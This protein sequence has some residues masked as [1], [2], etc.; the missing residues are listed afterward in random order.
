M[1]PLLGKGPRPRGYVR[2]TAALFSPGAMSSSKALADHNLDLRMKRLR[3]AISGG[4][5]RRTSGRT[6][7][8]RALILAPGGRLT[9]RSVPAPL[10]P[11]PLG[12]IVHPIAMATCDL[13]RAMGLGHTPF[14]LPLQ[15]GHE[16]V[17]EVVAIGSEVSRIRVGQVVVVPFQISCGEC[18][19][20]LAGHTGNCLSVPPVSMYG[21][22][23]GGGHWGGTLADELAVPFAD[24]VLVPL[25][26]GVDPAAAASVGD[27]ISDAHRHVAPYLPGILQRDPEA[28]VLI[29]AT[30]DR[31]PI[32]TPSCALYAG[33][34]ALA[35]GGTRVTYVDTRQGARDIAAGLGMTAM[36]PRDLRG[37]PLA[38]LVI[39]MTFASRGHRL[40][41]SHIAPDGIC[42]NAGSLHR[43]GSI[44][45]SLM[46]ARN[47]TLSVSR[48]HARS[49]IP[50]VLELMADGRV[51]PELV[52]TIQT[53]LDDA[54][55]ALGAHL[56]GQ[57]VKTVLTA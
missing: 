23:L 54:K 49:Q 42:S 26:A 12:A 36:S 22:G 30:V 34:F 32:F 44:P 11:G 19:S 29:I 3:Q 10:P 39:D 25:P 35:L 38:P 46:Y 50:G 1:E 18:S 27:N 31:R 28:E 17:A 52:T 40:A 43:H 48:S 47:V 51:R 21:F 33:Q 57:S 13:D 24:A 53:D 6:R 2:Q 41:L 14:P 56:A 15:F 9:W 4:V 45:L 5:R 37:H 8:M 20:C 55:E 16:C 7:H